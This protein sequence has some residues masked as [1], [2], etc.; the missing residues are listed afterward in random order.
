MGLNVDTWTSLIPAI[1]GPHAIADQSL[2][3]RSE[4]HIRRRP[5][6]EQKGIITLRLIG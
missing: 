3:V 2:R 6:T 1:S 4:N 5:S